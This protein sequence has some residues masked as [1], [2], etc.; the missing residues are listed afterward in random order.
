MIRKNY[1]LVTW[2]GL[3]KIQLNEKQIPYSLMKLGQDTTNFSYSETSYASGMKRV[4]FGISRDTCY[5]PHKPKSKLLLLKP[6]SIIKD[7]LL[8]NLYKKQ[9]YQGLHIINKF[10][11][12]TQEKLI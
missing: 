2:V 6:S 5:Y 4:S 7:F 10:L 8:G 1:S 12:R 3:I 11:Q 9:F